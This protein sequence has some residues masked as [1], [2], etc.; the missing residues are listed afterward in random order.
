MIRTQDIKA[1]VLAI[2]RAGLARFILPAD[3]RQDLEAVPEQLRKGI[4]FILADSV[5]EVVN[6]ALAPV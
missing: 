6:A 4:D 1:K 5:D 2:G 3:N